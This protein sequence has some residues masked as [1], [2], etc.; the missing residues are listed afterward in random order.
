[1]SETLIGLLRFIALHPRDRVH[2][3]GLEQLF[4]KR[5]A[6]F[7]RDLQRLVEL[8]ALQ[9]VE[10]EHGSGRRVFYEVAHEWSLWPTIRSLIVGLSDPAVLVREAIRDVEGIEAAFVYGSEAAGTARADSD[11]DVFVFGDHV[12]TRALLSGLLEV[13][14]LVG[15]EV[16]PGVYTH[17]K[18][19]QRLARP[20]APGGGFVRDVLGGP[21][22]WVAGAV[23]A[24]AP[25]A[26]AAGVASSVLTGSNNRSPLS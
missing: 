2:L 26:I 24:L 14:L 21:K 22:T 6:S 1:M 18:L 23:D 20:D 17:M 8:G 11:I 13:S 4:G 25:I 5:S 10:H 9:R 7:Q 19:A 15:R 3:R 16:N 12:N